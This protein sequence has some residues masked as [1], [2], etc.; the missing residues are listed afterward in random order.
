MRHFLL[1]LGAFVDPVY[2]KFT[3]LTYLED[4]RNIF[5]IRLTRYRG[6][7]IILSDGTNIKKNDLLVKIHFHNVRLLTELKEITSDIKKVKVLLKE[8]QRSLP[9]VEG[10]IRQHKDS[11]EIKGII[12]ITSLC[13]ASH[14]LGF[15]AVPIHQPVYKWLRWSTSLPIMLVSK[16]DFSIF[17]QPPPSYLFMS[18]NKLTE[19]YGIQ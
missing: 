1:R 12:G 7:D 4:S 14:R 17:K 19:L 15:D 16:K 8:V 2:F 5:R 6:R 3:R 11:S 9:G 13:S 10:Y 18:K